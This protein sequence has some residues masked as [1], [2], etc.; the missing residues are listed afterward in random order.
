MGPRGKILPVWF[1]P[2]IFVRLLVRRAKLGF[3]SR[4]Q[5]P[6]PEA[7]A[8]HRVPRGALGAV[9]PPAK[10]TQGGDG[11]QRVSAQGMSPVMDVQ[12]WVPTRLAKRKAT[13]KAPRRPRL[14]RTPR[15]RRPGHVPQAE[16]GT[17]ESLWAR[18]RRAG[19]GHNR[20]PGRTPDGPE[21][22]GCPH[23]SEEG[24]ERP[25]SAGGHIQEPVRWQRQPP[26]EVDKRRPRESSGEPDGLGRSRGRAIPR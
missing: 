6:T 24:G 21:E 12:A 23:S 25:W 2:L 4:R 3:A 1:T 16:S 7:L 5:V 18:P 26:P 15:G 20:Y 8:R 22:V 11:P 9:T 17:R 14:R 10:R 19:G 13:A